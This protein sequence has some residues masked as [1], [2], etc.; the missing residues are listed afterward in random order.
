MKCQLIIKADLDDGFWGFSDALEEG[1]S[2]DWILDLIREDIL[3]A[4]E[5][6][7]MELQISGHPIMADQTFVGPV[8]KEESE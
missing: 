8:S 6:G 2:N 1:A 3:C 4:V 7:E 5:K